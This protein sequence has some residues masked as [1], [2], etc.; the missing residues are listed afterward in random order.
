MRRLLLLAFASLAACGSGTQMMQQQPPPNGDKTYALAPFTLPPGDEQINCYYVPADGIERYVSKFTVDMN[1]GSHHLVV[2][3][4]NEQ[5]NGPMPAS[6]P[7]V[8][9][10]VEIPAGLDGMLP[11]SQQLHSETPL[12]DGVAMKIEAYHGLYFQ[13]HYINATQSTITTNVTYQLNTVDASTVTQTAGMIFY[14]NL[15]LNIPVGTSTST[16]MQKIPQDLSLLSAT[17]HM[18]MHGTEFVATV[19]GTQIYETMNW[20][21][22]NGALFAAP[23]MALTKGTPITWACSYDNTTSGPLVFGNSASKN[24]MCIFAGIYYPAA[25][26]ATIF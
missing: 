4:I 25:N 20:D 11:G 18:H 6:G 9:S 22:P 8:C 26:G 14:N 7:T 19:N 1:A 5:T 17:G 16:D 3:R 24:E 2:F 10:Q 15:A 21:E 13:S 12:P 23:G